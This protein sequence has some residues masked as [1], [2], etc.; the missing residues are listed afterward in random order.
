MILLC[1]G[2]VSKHCD[3]LIGDCQKISRAS[4]M[5][6]ILRT[7]FNQLCHKCQVAKQFSL[8][9]RTAANPY[10][11]LVTILNT[12]LYQFFNKSKHHRHR[13]CMFSLQ[14]RVPP[15]MCPLLRKMT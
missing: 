1:T 5:P 10:L 13:I 3:S 7:I 14:S 6:Q 11:A 8:Q 15:K 12:Q 4:N 2:R 9:T